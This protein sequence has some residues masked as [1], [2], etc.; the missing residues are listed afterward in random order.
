[1]NLE[2]IT[3]R[4]LGIFPTDKS[5]NAMQRT[6]PKYFSCLV[7][8]NI[9]AHPQLLFFNENFSKDLGLGNLENKDLDFLTAQ[10]LPENI[11]PFSTAYGG[12]QFGQ[13][14]SQLGDGR[15]IY[16]GEI[17]DTKGYFQEIQWKGAGATPF[18]RNADGRAVLR[19]SIRE[20]LM[21]E[22]MH[23]LNLPTT[24]ALSLCLTGENIMRDI[25]YNGNPKPEPGAVIVRTAESFLRFG[26]FEWFS[27]QKEFD[28]L[29]KLADF[30]INNYYTEISFDSE[31][32]YKE[33]FSAIC[34]RTANLIV[35]WYRVGFV[36]GVMNTDNMSILG[37]TIDFGPFAMLEEYD[38]N[39]TPNTSD[40]PG[41][42][43]AFGQQAPIAQW[44]LWKLANAMFPLI[45]DAEFLEKEL[46]NFNTYF[47]QQLDTMLKNKFGFHL[48]DKVPSF[49]WEKWE[50]LMES[51]SLDYTLFFIGL[52]KWLFKKNIQENF[53]DCYYSIPN[54]E[55]WKELENF[56]AEYKSLM[57]ISQ[58]SLEDRLKTMQTN[59]PKFVLRNY[60]LH[61]CI[62]EVTLGKMDKFNQLFKALQ[63]PYGLVEENLMQKR[64][65]HYDDKP[66][67]GML[68]CSS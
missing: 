29:K 46:E 8:P 47:Q 50:D 32:K 56:L 31:S 43:Y 45:E 61:E 54:D 40:L 30:V 44:N 33:L 25:L 48:E 13:W 62:E 1:M 15:A 16:V 49:F 51:H 58:S 14:A 7:K 59:N 57:E 60:L 36:H 34:K 5:W 53:Q 19:S 27:A 66:G 3:Q 55:K 23:H 26:H 21:S 24:R 9:F 42:R 4:Y 67:S 64:P 28:T 37:L 10:N 39:F 52:E 17:K 65:K 11:L 22:A 2:K 35:E 63:N 18:S 6:V 68:S 41:R 38:N 20:F 12:H